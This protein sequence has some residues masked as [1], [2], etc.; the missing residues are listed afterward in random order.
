MTRVCKLKDFPDNH[1]LFMTARMV[2]FLKD[3]SLLNEPIC[4][5]APT[6]Q[7]LAPPQ[8]RDGLFVYMLLFL[9]MQPWPDGI[10]VMS[11]CN[12]CG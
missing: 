2:A 8:K 11:V 12:K 7:H 5:L 1:F 10:G 4:V 9:D 6:A 3:D